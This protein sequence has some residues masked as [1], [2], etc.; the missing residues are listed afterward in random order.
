MRDIIDEFVAETREGLEA[1]EADLL[2]LEADG[3]DEAAINRLFRVVHTIKG[4][5]GMLGFDGLV[6]VAHAGETL[7]SRVRDGAAFTPRAAELLLATHDV[8]ETAAEH[9]ATSDNEPDLQADQLVVDLLAEADSAQPAGAVAEAPSA[10]EPAA[11]PAIAESVAPEPVAPEPVVAEIVEPTAESSPVEKIVPAQE[12]EP[13]EA[14]APEAPVVVEA[15]APV[16]PAPAP[17]PAPVAEAPKA[18]PAPVAPA[19]ATPK[20]DAHKVEA[21]TSIRVSTRLLDRLMDLAGELVVARNQVLA[22]GAADLD[23]AGGVLSQVTSELQEEV[24]RTRLQPLS[25]IWSKFPRTVR[26]LA[27]ACGKQVELE[28]D[29]AETLLD[30]SLIQAVRDPMTHAVRNSIDHGIE[31]PEA[32]VAAGKPE[33]GRILF[34]ARHEGGHV[35]IEIGDDGAGIDPEKIRTKGIERGLV[36]PEAAGRMTDAEVLQLIFAPGFSTAEKVSDVSGRGV[37]MDVVRT[38]LEDIG[39]S[40]ELDS[41]VGVGT[42]IRMVIPLT[43]AILP[44]V[45]LRCADRRYALA[46]SHLVEVVETSDGLGRIEEVAG[47]P[48]LRLRGELLPLTSLHE[49][50]SVPGEAAAQVIVVVRANDREYGLRVDEVDELAEIVVKPLSG[51]AR[52]VPVFQGATVLGD[53]DVALIIDANGIADEI[54]V[55]SHTSVEQ[56]VSAKHGDA[57]VLCQ[58]GDGQVVGLMLDQV[59]RLVEADMQRSS[60]QD[61]CLVDGE[62]ISVVCASGEES[63]VAVCE[64]PGG[65]IAVALR[66]IRGMHDATIERLDGARLA[67]RVLVDGQIIDV[68]DPAK[69]AAHEGALS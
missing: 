44:V 14:P 65:R 54:G 43:L 27:R 62:V 58:L 41:K 21:D 60:G 39:G 20:A 26:D 63:L 10:P 13:V 42:L 12:S 68:L 50:L 40:V 33:C 7:M 56:L 24:M 61:V 3:S 34:S 69:L 46:R 29:G 8:I 18:A 59:E 31:T 51:L 17:A 64:I 4:T 23:A 2:A 53:G 45:L 32:R 57:V 66:E 67:G 16:T 38:S 35:I 22:S 52:K 11:A 19:P 6:K 9:L 1:I 30:R 55:T 25:T 15:S 47:A 37:G 28:M 36:T 48:V 49:R 5:A